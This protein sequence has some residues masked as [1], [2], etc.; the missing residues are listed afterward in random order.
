MNNAVMIKSEA[1]SVIRKARKILDRS[2]VK[3]TV[4]NDKGGHC[5]LGAFSLASGLSSLQALDST[6]YAHVDAAAVRLHPELAGSIFKRADPWGGKDYFDRFPAVFINNHLGKEAILAVYD[7]VIAQLETAVL[8]KQEAAKQTTETTN[9]QWNVE[10]VEIKAMTG[11]Y[12]D[13]KLEEAR[14]IIKEFVSRWTDQKLAEVT[15][16][17]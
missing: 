1:L 13:L 8:C 14:L 3:W 5:Q 4:D 17:C 9:E 2:Y 11:F 15:S 7:D 16:L 10:P 6:I 12:L